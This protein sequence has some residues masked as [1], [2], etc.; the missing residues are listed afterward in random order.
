MLKIIFTIFQNLTIITFGGGLYISN[1]IIFINYC[2][3]EN[4]QAKQG[5]GIYS[6]NSTLTL[7][8]SCFYKCVATDYA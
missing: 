1:K 6:L 2:H 5:G 7:N 3:F 4:L 8:S